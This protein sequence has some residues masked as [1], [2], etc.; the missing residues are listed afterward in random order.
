ME[1]ILLER[2]EKL[3]Q[4]GD[5]VKVKAGFARNYLLPKKKALR[6]TEDNKRVFET[7]KAQLEAQNLEHRKEAESVAAKMDG[8]RVVLIRQAGEGGQ[9]YGSVNARDVA[10]ALTAAG[11]TIARHQVELARPIK[12][13]GLH[14]VIVRLHPEVT[15]TINANVARTPDEAEVQADTGRAVLGEEAQEAADLASQAAE[16][17]AA[18]ADTVFEEEVAD[19]VVAEA[20]EEAAE[21]AEAA[22]QEKAER[23]TRAEAAEG[24][25]GDADK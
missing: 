8:A 11:F 7:Q 17:V 12:T 15:V 6:A 10:E 16:A 5:V 9:L 25:A 1:V 20:I 13:L 18:Q 24:D 21:E 3:G 19:E 14:D 2:I 4:M 23:G 22:A